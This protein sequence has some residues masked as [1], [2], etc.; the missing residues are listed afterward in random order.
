MSEADA[1]GGG[2]SPSQ[3]TRRRSR[4]QTEADVRTREAQLLQLWRK[5]VPLAAAA[6]PRL[7]PDELRAS[8][9][10]VHRLAGLIQLRYQASRQDSD[11][12]VA[13]FML[14]HVTLP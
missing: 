14:A 11:Q 8:R 4:K 9:G 1:R 12:Q 13:D 6:W 7:S 5:A 3:D 10:N 2:E